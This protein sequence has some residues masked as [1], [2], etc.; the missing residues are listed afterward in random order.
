MATLTIAP[1]ARAATPPACGPD[2]GRPGHYLLCN[3]SLDTNPQAGG[4]FAVN[5]IEWVCAAFTPPSAAALTLEGA[6][7]LFAPTGGSSPTFFEARV[8]PHPNTNAPPPPP[9]YLPVQSG[10]LAVPAVTTPMFYSMPL[11][12]QYSVTG[13]F[14]VCFLAGLDDSDMGFVYDSAITPGRNFTNRGG[15]RDASALVTG[16][17]VVRASVLST[18]L[19]PWATGGE[20]AAG[21]TDAGVRDAA[22]GVDAAPAADVGPRPDAATG[23][24]AAAGVDAVATPDAEPVADAAAPTDGGVAPDGAVAP[25]AAAGVPDAAVAADAAAVAPDAAVAADAAASTDAGAMLPAPTITSVSPDRGN[26]AQAVPL[27]I[28]GTGFTAGLRVRIGAV[29]LADPSLA[30]TT[31]IEASVPPGLAAGTYDVLV[32]NPDGQAAVRSKAYTVVVGDPAVADGCT[33][34][35]APTGGRAAELSLVLLAGLVIRGRRR[36]G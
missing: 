12:P 29:Q 36:R 20:C 14:R 18:E 3:D 23:L 30:G 34:V 21:A 1:S 22:P 6:L 13:E 25:D 27:V 9:Q 7:V 28:T 32:Q 24:D 19:A 4:P 8:Y 5:S 16:D 35:V 33:C 11:T 17:F 26:N 10:G 2:C 15:W 31:T